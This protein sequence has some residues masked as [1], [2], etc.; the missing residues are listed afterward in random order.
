MRRT[1][2]NPVAVTTSCGSRLAHKL[3]RTPELALPPNLAVSLLQTAP[4]ASRSRGWGQYF[5]SVHVPALRQP[6]ENVECR[7]LSATSL[8]LTTRRV[9]DV[10]KRRLPAGI[11]PIRGAFSTGGESVAGTTRE[12]LIYFDGPLVCV[13]RLGAVPSLIRP[14]QPPE[15]GAALS[16][17]TFQKHCRPSPDRTTGDIQLAVVCRYSSRSDVGEKFVDLGP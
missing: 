4:P 12:G 10:S 11:S 3:L 1:R 17:A 13:S 7:G 8:W 2:I 15:R 9:A 14:L 5:S 6:F 16:C